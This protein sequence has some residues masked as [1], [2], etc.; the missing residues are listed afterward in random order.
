LYGP[1][2]PAS[3]S[4]ELLCCRLSIAGSFADNG[5]MTAIQSARKR[6]RWNFVT[7]NSLLR[8]D[9]GGIDLPIVSMTTKP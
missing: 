9:D 8:N 4:G 1:A 7:G 5:R 3:I 2:L 6:I